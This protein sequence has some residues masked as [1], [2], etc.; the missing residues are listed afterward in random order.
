MKQRSVRNVISWAGGKTRLLP[1]IISRLPPA[2]AGVTSYVEPF[3][4]GAS[5]LL[6]LLRR[7]YYKHYEAGDVNEALIGTWMDI[8]D[9]AD[10][11]CKRLRLLEADWTPS[12]KEKRKELYYQLRGRYNALNR[13][14]E[15]SLERSVLFLFLT[16]T[17]FSSAFRVNK[18][19]DMT[20]SANPYR[21]R[22]FDEELIMEANRL[23]FP[24]NLRLCGYADWF[25]SINADTFV[26]LDPPYRPTANSDAQFTYTE[27]GFT[28]RDQEELAAF[29]RELDRK[30]AKILLSNADTEDGFFEELY[31]GFRIE[32]VSVRR[33]LSCRS[34]SPRSVQELLIRNY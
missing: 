3:L 19:G 9:H 17:C 28:D 24:V 8:R 21:K 6:E 23:V 1:E 22:F 20:Q 16:H 29:V 30:G 7:G 13:E 4:G 33:T 25:D 32:R 27:R 34:D 11:L 10:E 5:V 2:E 18:N 31:K 14:K 15:R 26:Y 12:T